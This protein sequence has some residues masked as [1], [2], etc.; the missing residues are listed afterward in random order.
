[1]DEEG[2][3]ICLVGSEKLVPTSDDLFVVQY[4]LSAG[5]AERAK[6]NMGTNHADCRNDARVLLVSCDNAGPRR[7]AWFWCC[8][9]TRVRTWPEVGLRSSPRREPLNWI[10]AEPSGFLCEGRPV[11]AYTARISASV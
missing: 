9:A 2:V 10:Q 6:A 4:R 3:L 8:T 1:M 7:S 11:F 5:A